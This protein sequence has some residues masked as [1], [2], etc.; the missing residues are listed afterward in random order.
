MT[1]PSDTDDIQARLIAA[2]SINGTAVYDTAGEKLGTVH[3]V[4]VDR[5]SG[6]V[7]Y[8]ILSFGGFLGLGRRHHPL[9]RISR[10][11]RTPPTGASFT[12]ITGTPASDVGRI[13]IGATSRYHAAR[14]PTYHDR[15]SARPPVEQPAKPVL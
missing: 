2:S 10:R 4:M 3:D 12:T 13:G 11:G 9:P 14:R 6:K 5:L 8:A 7:E 1:E 15:C